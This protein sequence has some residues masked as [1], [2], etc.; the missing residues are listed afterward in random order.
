VPAVTKLFRL[1]LLGLVT[2][3]V[4]AFPAVSLGQTVLSSEETEVWVLP[5]FDMLLTDWPENEPNVLVLMKGTVLNQ[6]SEPITEIA[7]EIPQEAVV[8][9]A[10]PHYRMEKTENGQRVVLTPTEPITTE[11]GTEL[12]LEYYYNPISGEV[13]K[14]FEYKFTAPY[15][16]SHLTMVVKEPLRSSDF[17][18]QPAPQAGEE[19]NFGFTSTIHRF[20]FSDVSPD[21]VLSVNVSYQKSDNKPSIEK[22]AQGQEENQGQG[23]EETVNPDP[24]TYNS[25]VIGFSLL[26]LMGL[27]IL[28]VFGLNRDQPTGIK[29]KP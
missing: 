5:E 14:N 22:E 21:Q 17:K 6:G 11:K 8:F 20:Q 16:I 4:L 24:R 10:S 15:E 27:G 28:L 25:F 3:F 18:T 9:D 1:V 26:F 7:V 23:P 29:K 13:D 12:A 19:N 2:A